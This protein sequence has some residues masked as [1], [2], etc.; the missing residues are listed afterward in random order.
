VYALLQHDLDGKYPE[1]RQWLERRFNDVLLGKAWSIIAVSHEGLLGA[2]IVTPK[3]QFA[4]K[5]ST[6]K[7]APHARRLGFGRCLLDVVTSTWLMA[8]IRDAIVTLD[9]ADMA[10]KAYFVTQP[11]FE[12]LAFEKNRYGF[13]RNEAIFRWVPDVTENALSSNLH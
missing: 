3:G 4:S 9:D 5:L 11:D 6:I 8:G 1:G 12:A 2:A 10:T 7:V 13:G